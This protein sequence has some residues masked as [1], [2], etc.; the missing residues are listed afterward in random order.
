MRVSRAEVSRSQREDKDRG[1]PPGR[2]D[3]VPERLTVSDDRAGLWL[4]ERVS[5]QGKIEFI[6]N[7]PFSGFRW[8]IGS[9]SN[10][11]QYLNVYLVTWKDS[12]KRECD[13]DSLWRKGSLLE[14]KMSSCCT[15]QVPHHP[16]VQRRG[17]HPAAGPP[18]PGR[19]RLWLCKWP[20]PSSQPIQT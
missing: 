16:A 2:H 5:F 12:E 7:Q 10:S 3:Q 13:L 8:H 19:G 18:F 15:E 4:R 14:M 20:C 17:Q 1:V 9:K 11:A 6:W